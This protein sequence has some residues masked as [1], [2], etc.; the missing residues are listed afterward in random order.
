[1]ERRMRALLPCTSTPAVPVLVRAHATQDW[2]RSCHE[3]QDAVSVQ[4]MRHPR[5]EMLGADVTGGY[6]NGCLVTCSF[7]QRCCMTV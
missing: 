3:R 1:M 5:R 4:L 6:A 2:A 7:M